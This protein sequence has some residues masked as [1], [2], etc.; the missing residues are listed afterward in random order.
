MSRGLGWY[1]IQLEIVASFTN[2]D[3]GAR[4]FR[5]VLWSIV[6][7]KIR[8]NGHKV[9]SWGPWATFANFLPLVGVFWHLECDGTIHTAPE[10]HVLP[11]TS[12]TTFTIDL[13]FYR[14]HSTR[15]REPVG[16][17]ALAERFDGITCVST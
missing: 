16:I 2:V 14:G 11:D 13:Q 4:G 1:V 5:A 9:S 6:G 12:D 15:L 7:V 3:Y 17:E 10:D 8:S